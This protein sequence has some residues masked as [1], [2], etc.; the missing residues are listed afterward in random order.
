MAY[1]HG[2]CDSVDHDQ[3]EDAVLK[4]LWSH[5][6]PD[7]VLELSLR[8]VTTLRLR[9][10]RKLYTLPLQETPLSYRMANKTPKAQII[11]FASQSAKTEQNQESWSRQSQYKIPE[12]WLLQMIR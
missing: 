8:D 4:R 11:S 2:E 5:K 9:F 7:S 6:P 1:L 10:Q 12:L 3:D